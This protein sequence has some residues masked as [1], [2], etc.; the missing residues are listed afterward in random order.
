MKFKLTAKQSAIIISKWIKQSSL[1]SAIARSNQSDNLRFNI[2]NW[3][4]GTI[5]LEIW[6]FDPDA[7]VKGR[8][9][10]RRNR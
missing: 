10:I 4:N 1:K 7:W 8:E 3:R 2:K 6:V 9:L 5:D